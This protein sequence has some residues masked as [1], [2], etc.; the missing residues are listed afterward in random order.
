MLFH[1]GALWRL[2]EFGYLPKLKRISSVSGGSIIAGV[3]GL[4]WSELDFD[5]DGVSPRFKEVIVEPVR[6]VAGRTIDV[7]VVL[8]GVLLPGSSVAWHLT[9]DYRRRLFGSATLRDLPDETKPGNP[10][11]V[12]TA[13]N[14]QSGALWRFAK[15]YTWDYK[16]GEIPQPAISLASAVAASSAFPPILAPARFR[17]KASDYAPKSRESN[18]EPPFTTRPVLADGG[19]YDNLGLQPVWDRYQTVLVSDGGGAM[20][21]DG[22]ALWKL[23]FW[24]WRDWGTQTKRVLSVI[25]NQV[26]DLRKRQVLS[27]FTAESGTPQ[28]RDGAYWGIRSDLSHYSVGSGFDCPVKQTMDLARTKTRLKRLDPS[29]QE[30]LINW[31]YA[32]C[33]SAMRSWVDSSLPTSAGYP[34]DRGV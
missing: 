19:V 9:R 14:L 1:L 21:P 6:K 17:F 27:G 25:D 34:Y 18:Q 28:A 23:R 16:V 29:R 2:N 4:H 33:D 13:T 8:A 15:P 20:E 12:I 31:G 24:R 22:G 30:R 11:F 10:R 26:R 5:G 3:L 32:V 7:K